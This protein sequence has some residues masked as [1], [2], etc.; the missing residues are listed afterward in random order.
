MTAQNFA[1]VKDRVVNEH[2]TSFGL[3]AER[4]APSV[5]N[6]FHPAE[7]ETRGPIAV[8]EYRDDKSYDRW[9]G[10]RI[11]D[12]MTHDTVTPCMTAYD[13]IRRLSA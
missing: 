3:L 13:L 12:D 11:H 5:W 8:I 7:D 2:A 6:L 9:E 4:V 1:A 10:I